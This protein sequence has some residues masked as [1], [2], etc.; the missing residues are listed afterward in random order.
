M[1]EVLIAAVAWA[2]VAFLLHN[3]LHESAHAIAA[4]MYGAT[5][6]RIWPFPSTKTGRF[7]WAYCEW[8]GVLRYGGD[9]VV[10]VAPIIVE[11]V[12]FSAMW[13]A[14]LVVP[15][16]WWLGLM[17]SELLA[18]IIDVAVWVAPYFISTASKQSDASL[19]Q[20][21]VGGSLSSKRVVGAIGVLLLLAMVAAA[22]L[23]RFFAV[24]L[25]S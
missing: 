16:G 21:V 7:T 5:G 25:V 9:K 24:L 6:I 3:V 19:F 17:F 1:I 2:P 12:W 4:K 20:T 23:A 18:S 8:S 15:F 13:V 11:L 10:L 14:I 22:L